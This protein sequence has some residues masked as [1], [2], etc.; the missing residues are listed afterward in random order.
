MQMILD[1]SEK[2]LSC[3]SVDIQWTNCTPD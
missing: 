1:S 2:Y 3:W